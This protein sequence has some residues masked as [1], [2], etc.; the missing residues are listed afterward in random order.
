MLF[1][2]EA[3]VIISRHVSVTCF[4][5]YRLQRHTILHSSLLNK[6]SLSGVSLVRKT[7]K[8]YGTKRSHHFTSSFSAFDHSSSSHHVDDDND[9]DDEENGN[10][11]VSVPQT[12]QENGTSVTKMSV[13]VTAEEKT[14]K[15]NDVKARSLLLMALPNE[16][17]LTFSQYNDAKTMFAAI[18]TRFGEKIVSRLAILGVVITQEDL[19]SKFLRSLPPEWNTHVVVWMNK[20]DIETMSIDDLYNNFKI[21]EQDVKKS[22]GASSG[23]QNLAFLTTPSTSSTNHT[24]SVRDNTVYAFIDENLNGSNVLHQDLE[25]IH[26][27]DLEAMDLKWQLSLL[28]VRAK[29]YYQ[30]TGKKIFIN[31]NDIAG[32]DKSKVECYNCHKLGYFARECRAP[33]SKES[34]F[35]NQDNIRKQ[36]NNKDKSSKAMLAI[37]GVG[38]DWSDMAEEQVQ[39][40]MALMA[41]LDSEVYTDKTCSKTYLK[42]YET[43][44]K[45]CEDLLVKL[46]ESEFKAITYKRDDSKENSDDSLVKEQVSE[47]TSSFVESSLNVDKETVFLDKKIEFVKPKNHEKPVK[48]SVRYAEMYRSQSPRG[49]QRNWNG[50]KSNQLGSDFVMYNKACFICGSFDHVQAHCKYHQRER[51]VYGNNYNRVNYNYTTNRTHPNAQRNMVPRAVLM[52]TGLKPFNTARTV[53]TAHPKSTVFSA[54]PMSCFSKS[55]QSTVKRPYQSKTVLTNKKFTQKNNTAKAKAVN[56]ARPKA[57]NTARPHSAVVNV[58]R[59]NQANVVKASACWGKPQQDDTGFIDSGCSRHMT[60]NIAYLSD[61][62]EF[63][64][65]YVT[66]G[67]GAHGGRISGKGTLKTDSLDF[68]DDET[69]EILKNFIKEIENLVD[70]KVKIIRSDNGTEFKNKVM[71]DFCREKGIKREYSVARTPQQNGMAERR[72]RTLI[73]A[74][75]TMLADSKLPTTFWAKAVSTA[76]YV[77]NRVL[78]V[79]PHNK[80]PYELFRGLKPALSFMRPFG[81]HV[82]ILN[83]LDNLGKFDGKSDEGFFVGYSLSSKAFRVY[84]TRTR[85]VEENLHI[86]FLENKPMIEGN[87]P[88][89]LFDIDSLTQSMNYVPVVAGTISNESAGTQGELNAG[90]ST[91]KEEISQDCIVMPIWKDAS[92][93]DSPSKDVGNGEPKSASDDQKQVEDGSH[94]ESDEKDKSKDD[95][96]PKEVNAAGQHVNTASPEVNTGR[97]KLNIVDPS[98][99]TA[100]SNDQDSPKDMFKLGA[101]H[102]LEATHVEFFSDEDEPEVDLGNITNSYTVPTTPNTRIHKDHPIKNVIGD[103]KSTIQTRRM[104]KSTSEQGFLSA[105]YEQKTHD[106]LNTCLYACFLS[107]IEP[108][109]I[110][111]ALSD[112][113][114]VEAMQEELL[115]FKLQQGHRQEEGIDYEEVFAPVARIEAIRLFLAYA[116]FMGFKDPA[117]PDKVYKVVKAL[118]GLHQAPRAW[119][120]TLANYLLSNGFKRGKID[121]TLFIKK[122]KGDILLVQVYVDDIIFGSTNKGC[123]CIEKAMK[124]SFQ[125]SSVGELTFFLGL[126]SAS[127]PVDLEKPL[128]KDGDANDV[129][130]HLYRSMIGYLMYLIASRPDIMFADSPFELVAYTDSDYAGATQ[131]RKST[132]RD[133]LTKGFDVGRHVKR[134]RDTKIP[135]SSGPPV[136]VGDEAVHKELGDRMERA[137][138]TASSLEAEQDSGNINRTQS[139]ATL[140]EP[141]P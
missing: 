133:L 86:R 140:N 80:T 114:W 2:L 63:D 106:T 58:V 26:E 45:Q 29:K 131:D 75:R 71:D 95:S 49:N 1:V 10:S 17:Q 36:R 7:R 130:V 76:C 120:E 128:V 125:M 13:L 135:Q 110:A 109:S 93:F 65:G 62:K 23:A 31:A 46:N 89:W 9:E 5:M 43:L 81:C 6:W 107:Q 100:S 121:Q 124:I 41:F 119:Y 137:A 55:A 60:G 70:K 48:K 39:T 87:G 53:N 8:D 136:K 47:D 126:Q 16:H 98:V 14:N 85:R 82:T 118:Y 24:V 21:V 127:T 102:T 72:N 138:T 103:V 134:G 50:Q 94:N 61:F 79:K 28:S 84:N 51:M 33:R 117:H 22:V 129:D 27:Y 77:Q 91:Q 97:F 78:V 25:Q 104:T 96:S 15:K 105:V 37:D 108:T 20:A 132:T 56:T 88:K 38:F 40:N 68:E 64:G 59:V 101:S 54:K 139:M 66:F 32:Y 123:V 18:E 73:E 112:S 74:A 111:K 99:N 12:T 57:V 92:Y 83:T 116:S 4:I 35:K 34:Q 141:S 3:T 122:Q 30:R 67:G 115:Q 113:S 19:N 44:K 42:N 11:W 90:T 69:S 52:K